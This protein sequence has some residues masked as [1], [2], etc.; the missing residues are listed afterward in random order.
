MLAIYALGASAPVIDSA[1]Q[2]HVA[3]QRPSI[4]SP[5]AITADTFHDHLGEREYALLLL[6]PSASLTEIP[7]D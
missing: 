3:Y 6:R 4:P 7:S 5:S 1:Y 2:T